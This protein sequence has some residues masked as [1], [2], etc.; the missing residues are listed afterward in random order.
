MCC[1]AFR[2]VSQ[3]T[4][5]VGIIME[6]SSSMQRVRA[7]WYLIGAAHPS[8]SKS[9]AYPM[10]ACTCQI[11]TYAGRSHSWFQYIPNMQQLL[12]RAYA[13]CGHAKYSM[14]SLAVKGPKYVEAINT[15]HVAS[16]SLCETRAEAPCHGGSPMPEPRL[17]LRRQARWDRVTGA[18]GAG[19]VLSL[20]IQAQASPSLSCL[21]PSP[22]SWAALVFALSGRDR[23]D[24]LF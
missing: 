15:L 23:H 7:S 8:I 11:R 17:D 9:P 10:H 1:Q 12:V 13:M 5:G 20:T 24:Q 22:W 14:Q 4:C 3:S 18:R 6:H 19:G 16:T 21:D 2:F